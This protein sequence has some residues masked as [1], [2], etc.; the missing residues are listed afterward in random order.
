[1]KFN[2]RAEARWKDHSM[3]VQPETVTVDHS[4]DCA[5]LAAVADASS[6]SSVTSLKKSS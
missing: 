6:V 2:G 4:D 1:M 3:Q 5:A